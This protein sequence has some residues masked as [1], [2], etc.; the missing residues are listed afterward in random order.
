[1]ANI[2]PIQQTSAEGLFRDR[3]SLMPN[4]VI[5]VDPAKLSSVRALI[6]G[7]IDITQLPWGGNYPATATL[8][9]LAMGSGL[10][11]ATE[12]SAPNATSATDAF[13]N[14]I[15]AQLGGPGFLVPQVS[16]MD[17]M[18]FGATV[19]VLAGFNAP[20]LINVSGMFQNARVNGITGSIN[21]T[22]AVAASAAS[23]FS[24]AVMRGMS[25]TIPVFN[26]VV[27]FAGNSILASSSWDIALNL[28]VTGI[29]NGGFT[30][31]NQ[32]IDLIWAVVPSDQTMDNPNFSTVTFCSIRFRG[33]APGMDDRLGTRDI[34]NL[35]FCSVADFAGALD[36]ATSLGA[37]THFQVYNNSQ[38][39]QAEVDEVLI[40]LHKAFVI[41]GKAHNRPQTGTPWT[42][43]RIGGNNANPSAGVISNQVAGLVAAGFTV[44]Y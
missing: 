43:I 15:L 39:S 29:S 21:L 2:V 3:V 28:I 8:D 27:G 20:A 1:M 7:R 25:T 23:C 9:R 40:E 16:R 18:L 10:I 13:R 37:F 31:L 30:V 6:E 42:S 17:N 26:S 4:R 22:P 12:L 14:T 32:I 44:T 41:D 33:A 24:G 38:L 19:G 35:P 36:N 34:Q 5:G 11:S